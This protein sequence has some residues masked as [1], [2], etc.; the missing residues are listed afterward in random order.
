MPFLC[1]FCTYALVVNALTLTSLPESF[2]PQAHV[3]TPAQPCSG[4]CLSFP[5]CVFPCPIVCLSVCQHLPVWWSVVDFCVSSCSLHPLAPSH[6]PFLQPELPSYRL[7]Y[8]FFSVISILWG[9]GDPPQLLLILLLIKI[10]GK[11]FTQVCF[12]I[13]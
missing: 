7:P 12:I 8:S 4:L 10:A 13:T 2:Y 6:L 3:S 9:L 5:V 11:P 1:G